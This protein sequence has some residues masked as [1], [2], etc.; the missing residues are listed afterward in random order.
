MPDKKSLKETAVTGLKGAWVGGTMLVPGVS[1]GSMAMIL[2]I[3]DRLVT[4]VSSFMEERKANLGF[5]CAFCVGAVLGMLLFAVPI[6]QLLQ[7]YP[8][9]VIYFFLGAVAGGIPMIIRKAG[10]K[11][12]GWRAVVYL[13][14]GIG[15]V[16]L[17]SMVPSGNIAAQMDMGLLKVLFLLLAGMVAAVALV[18]PGISVSYL[19]LLLGL[20][21]ETMKAI[22]S[23]NIAF[24]LPLGIGVILGILLTTK[25]LEKAMVNYPQMTY[26][27][28]LG[29]ILGSVAEIFPGIPGG[30][31]MLPCIL[32]FA[33]GFAAIWGMSR[34][35][36]IEKIQDS[37][38]TGAPVLRDS[39]V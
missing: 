6:L 31:E 3:Y 21:E 32:L 2:G 12:F 26:L 11:K 24:L 18:L 19:L 34:L 22:G 10:M 39:E 38:C 5:L 1:G 4:A 28:I 9:P 30:T 33:A 29:F 13:A 35:E 23:L 25:A 14:A 7:K 17:L 16:W 37:K 36:K 27:V 15:A 20:Y 8:M